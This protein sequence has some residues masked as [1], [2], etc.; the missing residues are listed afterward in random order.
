MKTNS[1]K[2]ISNFLIA[3]MLVTVIIIAV[4]FVGFIISVTFNLNIFQ[5]RT[6]EFAFALIGAAFGIVASASFLNISLDISIISDIKLAEFIQHNVTGDTIDERLLVEL[7]QHAVIDSS[8]K[9]HRKVLPWLITFGAIAF[10][11]VFLLVGDKYSEMSQRRNMGKEGVDLLVR[12]DSSINK[13]GNAIGNK[14]FEGI[15]K[16]IDILSNQKKEFSRISIVYLDKFDG[17]NIYVNVT[18]HLDSADIKKDFLNNSFYQPS[19]EEAEFFS[20]FFEKNKADRY[21]WNEGDHYRL[22]M[23]VIV[24]STKFIVIG[25]NQTYGR[26]G[27]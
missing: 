20:D 14:E 21:F 17:Q 6:T 27:S 5:S 4:W 15:P 8:I 13:I 9:R 2:S 1:K 16:I 25:S 10:V 22:Y 23:P 12:F 18:T 24:D 11:A 7:P 26:V 3:I 19:E